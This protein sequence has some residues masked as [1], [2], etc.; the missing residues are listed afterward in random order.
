MLLAFIEPPC[1][2]RENG[3]PSLSLRTGLYLSV[4]KS[5]ELD[6]LPMDF[7]ILGFPIS[8]TVDNPVLRARRLPGLLGDI[9]GDIMEGG[10]CIPPPQGGG[11]TVIGG[12]EQASGTP[13]PTVCPGEAC[14]C[15]GEY[16]GVLGILDTFK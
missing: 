9:N 1:P 13:T 5:K 11:V 4:G 3:D 15:N 2:D 7:P 10:G 6:S 8:I 12:D 16:G 14:D